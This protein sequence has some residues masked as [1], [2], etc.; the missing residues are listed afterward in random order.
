MLH[1]YV[2]LYAA[3]LLKDGFVQEAI[4]LYSTYGSPAIPQNFNIYNKIAVDTFAMPDLSGP[5]GYPTWMQLRQI[6]NELVS[7]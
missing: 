1:K 4:N 3:Q 5:E 2:A 7:I 6:L